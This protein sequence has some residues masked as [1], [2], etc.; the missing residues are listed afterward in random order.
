MIL[1]SDR[2]PEDG[3]L[4]RLIDGEA[5]PVE[6]SVLVEHLASC[7]ACRSRRDRFERLSDRFTD[8][9][10]SLDR[11]SI[12][13]RPRH[14]PTRGWVLGALA[15]LATLFLVMAT[16]VLAWVGD[17]WSALRAWLAAAPP[18]TAATAPIVE[19]TARG[20][21][22]V[23]EVTGEPDEGSVTL[24]FGLGDRFSIAV[25]GALRPAEI[26][27]LDTGAVIRAGPAPAADYE[28]K[29]PRS[30]RALVL[31]VQGQ[32][33]RRIP[34]QDLETSPLRLRL[35]SLVP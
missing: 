1:R 7:A 9:V 6:E 12:G 19:F 10:A 35:G 13:T 17:G 34:V 20:E 31:Q 27:I 26:I 33:L 23:L 28:V 22:F 4:L 32:A 25:S 29:V 21:T 8:L 14:V 5:D 18:K 30:V 16:P 2:H 24:L 15:M 3:A 11:R